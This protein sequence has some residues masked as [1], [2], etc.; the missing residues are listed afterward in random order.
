MTHD[1]WHELRYSGISAA[2]ARAIADSAT[3][4]ASGHTALRILPVG[5]IAAL[6][7]LRA[8]SGGAWA[9][10]VVDTPYDSS[11]SLEERSWQM[12][13]EISPQPEAFALALDF[14]AVEAAFGAIAAADG[15]GPDHQT[16]RFARAMTRLTLQVSA[17]AA[18][19]LRL[20]EFL[21]TGAL[22]RLSFADFASVMTIAERTSRLA[23]LGALVRVVNGNAGAETLS[24]SWLTQSADSCS[25]ASESDDVE[26]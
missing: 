2:V 4:L 12:G 1:A 15:C 5:A 18:T 13:I 26:A 8:L 16:W 9:V 11:E 21:E 23:E 24:P 19:F 3:R 22:H 20:G 14:E 6:K 7:T 25:D 10:A 17:S